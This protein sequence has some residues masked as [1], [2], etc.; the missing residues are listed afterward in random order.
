MAI[1]GL[2]RLIGEVSDAIERA[3]VAVERAHKAAETERQSQLVVPLV[4]G[5]RIP[6]DSRISR[7]ILDSISELD[8]DML[9]SENH[10]IS[11]SYIGY[12]KSCFNLAL[13]S[14]SFLDASS[15]LYKK[16]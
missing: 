1:K 5:R 12:L 4:I 3:S 7:R 16:R 10:R 6:S 15:H 8:L 11:E 9:L 13:P 14:N 2:Q